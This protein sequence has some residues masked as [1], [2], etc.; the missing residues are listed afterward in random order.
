M[1][2]A[3]RI[4]TLGLVAGLLAATAVPGTADLSGFVGTV[5]FENDLER[6]LGFS[7]ERGPS[8]GALGGGAEEHSFSAFSEA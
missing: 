3:I 8:G 1:S 7:V 2:K 6:S 5:G 4:R